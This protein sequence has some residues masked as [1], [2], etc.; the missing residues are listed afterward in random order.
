MSDR[1][2]LVRSLQEALQ[3]RPEVREAYLFGSQARGKTR[4]ESDVDV[5]VYVDPAALENY[6]G[7]FGY[8]A[9]IGTELIGALRRND[10]DL[11]VLNKAPPLLY[12]HV[13]RDGIRLLTRDAKE[14]T[15]REAQALSR[16]FDYIPQLNKIDEAHRRRLR[17]A[18]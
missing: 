4:A 1:D 7:W 13:L 12:Y 6:V 11:V 17:S 2:Q 5:A 3:A 8:D 16:Y 9:E 15:T 10:V 18:K 14:T